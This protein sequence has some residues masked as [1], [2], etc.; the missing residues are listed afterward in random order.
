LRGEQAPEG[1]GNW[2]LVPAILGMHGNREGALGEETVA[3]LFNRWRF[4][5]SGENAVRPDDLIAAGCGVGHEVA[6]EQGPGAELEGVITE[7]VP[8]SHP[9][10]TESHSQATDFA[11]PESLLC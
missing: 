4:H 1:I 6:Q 11:Y 3:P 5:R 10:L 9:N 7:S 2:D 8:K